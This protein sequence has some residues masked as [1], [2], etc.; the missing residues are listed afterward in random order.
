MARLGQRNN[1]RSQL[2]NRRRNLRVPIIV[3]VLVVAVAGFMGLKFNKTSYAD[4]WGTFYVFASGPVYESPSN[5]YFRE[6]TIEPGWRS[7]CFQT[8]GQYYTNRFG[9]SSSWW[10]WH[11]A[12]PQG[13]VSNT[14]INGPAKLSPYSITTY[15]FFVSGNY[16]AYNCH[17]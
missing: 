17:N 14:F 3:G 10:V 4:N 8:K 12:Y 6:G 16:A 11:Q 5:N 15:D 2:N 9:Y 7:F 13:F 1:S